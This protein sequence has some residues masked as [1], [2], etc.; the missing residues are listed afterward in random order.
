MT[1]DELLDRLETSWQGLRSK[2]DKLAPEDFDRELE[3]GGTAREGVAVAAFWNETCAPVFAWMRGRP[4]VPTGEWYGGADLGLAPGEPWPRD[5]VHHTR[6]AAWA[7]SV[8]LDQV[9]ERLESAHHK[10]IGAINSL[11][12]AEFAPGGGQSDDLPPD[13]PWAKLTNNERMV[14]KASDCTYVLYDELAARL[15]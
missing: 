2:L 8:P 14:A 5:D 11:T 10:A 1:R 12:D 7:R 4:E 6:E 3:G 15:G 9:L 13:H